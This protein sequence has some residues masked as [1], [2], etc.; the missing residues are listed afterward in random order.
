MAERSSSASD[1]AILASLDAAPAAFA[2]FYRRH[3][4]QLLSELAGRT[5]NA[6]LAAALCA[7]T[8]AAALAAAHRFGPER[9]PAATWLDAI[10]EAEL[11]HAERTGRARDRFRRRLGLAELEPP[12][13]ELVDAGR[14]DRLGAGREAGGLDADRFVGGRDALPASAARF[15]ADLEEEL[16]AAARF[17]ADRRAARPPLPRPPRA[18]LLGVA[19]LMVLGLVAALALSGG[20]DEGTPGE[21]SAAALPETV[22]FRLAAMQPLDSCGR[23]V[24]ESYEDAG[25]IALLRRPQR[26]GDALPFDPGRLPIGTFDPSS[27]RRAS[28]VY[29]VPSSDVS[30]SGRCGAYVGPGLCLVAAAREF[31]C[32]TAVD[33]EWGRAVARTDAGTLVG[34]VPDGV[35]RVTIADDGPPLA[36]EVAGNVYRARAALPA[37]E[38]IEVAFLRAGDRGCRRGVAPELLTEVALLLD[39]P[40]NE[41]R[42]PRAAQEALVHW[43]IEAIVEDGARYWGGGDGIDFWA[44]PVVPWGRPDCAPASR[45]CV[46]AIT[47]SSSAAAECDLGRR[48]RNWWLGQRFPERA[49]MFGTVPDGVTGV[50]LTHRGETAVIAAHDNVFGGSLPWPYEVG[51]QPRVELL[52]GDDEAG[53]LAG[54]VDAGGPVREMLGRLRARGYLTLDLITPAGNVRGRSIVYWWPGRAVREDAY[55]LAEA[56]GVEQVEPIRDTA[57][58]PLPVLETHAPFVV[59]VGG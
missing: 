44:V 45:V 52:R 29:V 57:R 16:V 17:Q 43:P 22:R 3:A 54:L 39:R 46:V 27:T 55:E 40:R 47:G 58:I 6:R 38:G 48:G 13:A 26:D 30:A 37:G 9:G 34:I 51:D 1:E 8:F 11:A 50:R 31:R 4:G 36:A 21:R 35:A 28:G 24:E 10:A 42:L 25:R 49:M 56:A 19:A 32:F 15:L 20:G 41:E 18:A 5:R 33:V 2:V 59:F 53:R 23:P 7:E 12:G 14:P